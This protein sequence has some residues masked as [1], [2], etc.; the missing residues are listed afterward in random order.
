VGSAFLLMPFGL[1]SVRTLTGELT[2]R[3]S[4]VDKSNPESCGDSVRG[5]Q[6]QT[7]LIVG[8]AALCGLALV[9]YF[10][11]W[12]FRKWVL[13]KLDPSWKRLARVY[14]FPEEAEA[15]EERNMFVSSTVM[16]DACDV[17]WHE[18][19]P[20]PPDALFG[21]LAYGAVVHVNAKH[22]GE[23]IE[24][25]L[26]RLTG[27]IVLVSGCDTEN[28]NVPGY[29]KIIESPNI[30]HWFLQNF[31]LDPQYEGQVTKLPLGLN[32]HKLE[33]QG[34]NT[35]S[36]MGLPSRPGNQQLTMKAIREDI[37]P[38]AERPA[39]VYANYHLS[40]DTFLRSPE[41]VK[42][43]RARQE[44]LDKTRKLPFVHYELR[45]IPRNE[46]WRR[47]RDYAFEMSPHGNGL[48]CHRTW[49]AILLKTVPIVKTSSLDSMYDG[50]P[51]VI[52]EDWSEITAENLAAWQARHAVAF[53]GPI[54]EQ[55]YCRYW[56]ER[57][58]S[59]ARQR[60]AGAA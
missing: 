58:R 30:L 9:F 8:A 31:E 21:P 45:Q 15:A 51:V 27:P 55:L 36:D 23:F 22:V 48:D 56:I 57:F 35:S 17:I 50:L 1:E 42:R 60:K 59:F 32:Y 33:P 26:P 19:I 7:V 43:A 4:S 5:V 16:R 53:D 14:E 47:H 41:A 18:K 39:R 29:E 2:N 37:P 49:E 52:V 12:P 28:S 3:Q 10:K 11:Y 13:I 24:S 54:P 25:V 38:F 34:D 44:A 40:M 46:V 20:M 6:V